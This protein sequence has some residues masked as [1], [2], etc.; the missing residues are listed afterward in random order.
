MFFTYNAP[1]EDFQE[2]QNL[3]RLMASMRKNLRVVFIKAPE[4]NG[5]TNAALQLAKQ[6]IASKTS[7]YVLTKQP[8]I[9][10]LAQQI[11]N[12]Q[13]ESSIKPDVHFVKYST[14]EDAIRAQQ[15]I[16]QEYDLLSGP[17][18]VSNEGVANVLD[19]A[20]R[21]INK[22]FDL[23]TTIRNAVPLNNANIVPLSTN[24]YLPPRTS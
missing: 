14:S 24:A 1:E 22:N 20:S 17:S 19:F 21:N 4:N 15:L 13:H 2:T 16:Q 10:E 11:N 5:L 18:H 9:N 8:D 12:I 3:Q 23:P 7:I 6:T